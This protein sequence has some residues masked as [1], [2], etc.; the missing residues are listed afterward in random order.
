M[1]EKRSILCDY[2]G[3]ELI[4]DSSHPHNYTL[5]LSCIDTGINTSGM[6]YGIYTIPLL[7]QSM[8]FC[9]FGCLGNWLIAKVEEGSL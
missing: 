6:V 3:S 1:T 8:H 4:V 9:G 7:R 5:E 2:C